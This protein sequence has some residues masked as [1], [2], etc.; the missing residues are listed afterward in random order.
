MSISGLFQPG[1]G[2]TGRQTEIEVRS[3]AIGLASRTPSSRLAQQLRATDPSAARR[4]LSD[5]TYGDRPF[6]QVQGDAEPR[7]LR[8][9]SGGTTPQIERGAFRRSLPASQAA[10]AHA[11]LLYHPLQADQN[12]GAARSLNYR[13]EWHL[14]ARRSSCDHPLQ[15][16]L[17]LPAAQGWP[18]RARSHRGGLTVNLSRRTVAGHST[19]RT[20]AILELIKLALKLQISDWLAREQPSRN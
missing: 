2:C 1:G 12:A 20:G 11:L 13:P 16:G 9:A 10:Q 19:L 18:T 4:G 17:R 15:R 6:S 5:R 7:S 8:F 14:V 3:P